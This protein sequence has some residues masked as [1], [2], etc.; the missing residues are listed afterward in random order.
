MYIS[1]V[2]NSVCGDEIGEIAREVGVEVARLGHILVCG[3]LGGVMDQAAK[4]AKEA[5]GEAVG[6][7]P[8]RDREG[9]SRWLTIAIP[10]GMGEGRNVIVA[11]A[12]DAMVAVG[13]ELGT[14]SEIALAL[15]MG[16]PV[17]GISSWDLG[18]ENKLPIVRVEKPDEA[19]RVALDLA[20]K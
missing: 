4:G 17:V 16:K 18:G 13:G 11:M 3:G 1:V 19:V 9:A 14:L 5:G 12:G 6:I 10:T 15:K 7:L 2:G 20:S 8:G